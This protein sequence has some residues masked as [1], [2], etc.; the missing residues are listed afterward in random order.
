MRV[1]EPT[2]SA[3]LR[4]YAADGSRA[5]F[6]EIVPRCRGLVFAT[7]LRITGNHTMAE[8][9]AQNVFAILVRMAAALS[10]FAPRAEGC[11]SRGLS[12]T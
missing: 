1:E 11:Y 5:A 9:A 12:S 6:K 4:E 8:E 7:A 3:L 10:L 2:L